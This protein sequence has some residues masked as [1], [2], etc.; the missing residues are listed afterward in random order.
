MSKFKEDGVA[1]QLAIVD[2]STMILNHVEQ[3]LKEHHRP[4]KI[5]FCRSGQD[6][7]DLC[8]Q[9]NVDIVIL[10]IVMQDFE[11]VE[12]LKCLKR[13]NSNLLENQSQVYQQEKFASVGSLA[14]GVAHEINNPLGFISGNVSALQKYTDKYV[15]ILE[16]VIRFVN[17]THTSELDFTIKE[18]LRPLVETLEKLDFEHINDD[19]NDIYKDTS[20]GISRVDRIVKNLKNF[21]NVDQSLE[22]GRYNINVG[23]ENTLLVAKNEIKYYAEVEF[24]LEEVSD[25]DASGAQ[26][27]QVILNMV[28]NAVFAIKMKEKNAMGKIVLHT[29]EDESA[30]YLS[31]RDNGV[32]ISNENISNVFNP[33]Y[34]TKPPGEGIGLGLSISYDII[35]QKHH[36]G[37]T[38][39]SE[40]GE[41]TTFCIILPKSNGELVE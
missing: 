29:W 35:V 6:I 19:I 22:H 16:D 11:G 31:I 32:G 28:L 39:E 27:N 30:V 12:N 26:I 17:D 1:M 10:D 5:M 41:G 18:Y 8:N 15:E 40:I 21:S 14:A 9:I 24:Q 36:G 2:D 23:V 7:L 37:L 25:I 34:T 33:F 4:V 38:V 13:L 3:I 20:E